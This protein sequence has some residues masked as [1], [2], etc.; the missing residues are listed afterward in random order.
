MA[1]K[2]YLGVNEV[3]PAVILKKA[4]VTRAFDKINRLT[5]LPRSLYLP[6]SWIQIE[7]TTKCNLRCTMCLRSR[8]CPDMNYDMNMDVFKLIIDQSINSQ[9]VKP[10]IKLIGLGEPLLNPK[11]AFMVEYAK[12]KGLTVETV[13]NFTIINPK[14]LEKLVEV[15]LD[16]LAISLDAASP[17]AFERIRVGAKFGEVINNIKLFLKIRENMNSVK[18]RVIFRTTITKEN[19]KEIPAITELA[20]SIA[21]DDVGFT[22]QIV[23]DK[24]DY[25]CPRFMTVG[26]EKSQGKTKFWIQKKTSTCPA[27]RRC[28][29]TYDGKVMPCNYLMEIMP[30]DKYPQFEF[31]DITKN[32]LHSIW[33]SKSYRQF[34]VRKALG[35]HPYFCNSCPWMSNMN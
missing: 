13:S 5:I 22:K 17:Q 14:V 27:M 34:R 33:F 8:T 9:F 29:I 28:Y 1:I 15:Q 25:E 20:K 19:V 16:S 30:R 32:S 11:I 4:L 3:N 18:P 10:V 23:S 31:G 12:R 7:P 24:E 6:P 2:N 21:V 26:A 35:F